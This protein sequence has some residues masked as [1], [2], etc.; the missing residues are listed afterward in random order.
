M[1]IKQF[2][3]LVE[4]KVVIPS[5]APLL[6]ALSYTYWQYK[7]INVTNTVLLIISAIM[8]H[9]AVNVYNR[10][11]DNKRENNTNF[12]R[13]QA[14]GE[15][16]SK[17]AVL[18]TALVLLLIASIAG[19]LV[20]YRTSIVT[21]IVGIVA[22]AI[23]YFY[24]AGPKPITN[25]P[26]GEIFAGITMGFG[27]FFAMI[28]VNT[29]INITAYNIWQWVI[30]S[31]PLILAIANILFANNIADYEEDIASGRKTSV[32]YL[33]LEKAKVLF[34]LLYVLIYIFFAV[35]M[36][37][38]LIPI[39]NIINFF[40]LVLVFKLAKQFIDN[41]VKRITFVNSIKCLVLIMVGMFI[42]YII[43]IF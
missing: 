11:E 38:K 6:V 36:L 34:I 5:V 39:T 22:F 23:G 37:L 33:G 17:R 8:V 41:P 2:F 14:S 42:S 21:W 16:I 18:T 28:Y 30:V 26:Y 13:D 32:Y 20:A 4:I 29:K 43:A 9:L 7:T 12:L 10:Y 25:T 3:D 1:T 31:L 19:I 27:I 40:L 35:A 24:S 15:I